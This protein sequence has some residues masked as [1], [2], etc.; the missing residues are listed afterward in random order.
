MCVCV[1][2]VC[3]ESLIQLTMLPFIYNIYFVCDIAHTYIYVWN[4]EMRNIYFFRR[5]NLHNFSYIKNNSR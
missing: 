3:F 2:V 1:C 5:N 4:N